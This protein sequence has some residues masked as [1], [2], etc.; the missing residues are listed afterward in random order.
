MGNSIAQVSTIQQQQTNQQIKQLQQRLHKTQLQYAHHVEQFH[1]NGI[2]IEQ[3]ET[4]TM[5]FTLTYQYKEKGFYGKIPELTI[6]F[7]IT[8]YATRQA[9]TIDVKVLQALQ[10]THKYILYRVGSIL[11]A[12]KVLAKEE[13]YKSQRTLPN[14]IPQSIIQ[15]K[16]IPE[17]RMDGGDVRFIQQLEGVDNDTKKEKQDDSVSKSNYI[18]Y[19]PTFLYMEASAGVEGKNIPY[20]SRFLEPPHYQ[21]AMPSIQHSKLQRRT[22]IYKEPSEPLSFQK[23]IIFSKRRN[24]LY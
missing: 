23:R 13:T 12:L 19:D 4:R 20:T 6:P 8:E 7:E 21:K 24:C 18:Q 10:P 14:S 5:A 1:V 3:N 16:F 11:F 17:M 15:T 9:Q 2:R 22:P